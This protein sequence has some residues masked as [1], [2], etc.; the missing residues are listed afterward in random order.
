M[1]KP[2]EASLGDISLNMFVFDPII[3]FLTVSTFGISHNILSTPSCPPHETSPPLLRCLHCPF[4]GAVHLKN[5]DA[6]VEPF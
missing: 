3:S 2:A 4:I 1:A 6:T 5:I